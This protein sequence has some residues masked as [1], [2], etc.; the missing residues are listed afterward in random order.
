MKK[1]KNLSNTTWQIFDNPGVM[2][3]GVNVFKVI[4]DSNGDR[5]TEIKFVDEGNKGKL[6]YEDT[7]VAT[8]PDG[9]W[10]DEKFQE[11]AIDGGED[12]ANPMLIS[13]LN[14]YARCETAGAQT[15]D[16][17]T[18]I[19]SVA[20]AIR[21]EGGGTG[22]N[23]FLEVNL[24]YS[25]QYEDVDFWDGSSATALKRIRVEDRSVSTEEILDWLDNNGTVKYV[26]RQSED[27]EEYFG[28][29][30][31]SYLAYRDPFV[32]DLQDGGK[33]YID[34]EN[35]LV[36]F[37]PD[38]VEWRGPDNDSI[39][40]AWTF[41]CPYQ[42]GY[43]AATDMLALLREGVSIV[44]GYTVKCILDGIYYTMSLSP[45]VTADFHTPQ[46]LCLY[47]DVSA[48]AFT[49]VGPIRVFVGYWD[50]E[51]PPHSQ[52]A[53]WVAPNVI[54]G[55]ITPTLTEHQFDF[56][57]MPG[58]TSF[59]T[60]SEIFDFLTDIPLENI[61]LAGPTDN[62]HPDDIRFFHK[63][64][65]TANNIVFNSGENYIS[66]GGGIEETLN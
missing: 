23:A 33:I 7:C 66:L 53:F 62:A 54:L 22:G 60:S 64:A 25:A 10:E 2:G 4:F 5:Y 11:I 50:Q 24:T 8:Y 19:N 40:E 6:Y 47:P 36:T 1:F 3:T 21:E 52:W 20:D 38:V 18:A 30:E 65:Y 26:V 27:D 45:T 49:T 28:V 29:L 48:Y 39:A 57:P 31:G 9:D 35:S 44:P 34:I 42:D 13:W 17:V 59:T 32:A 37:L 61:V 63:Y 14:K 16:I 58:I 41:K 43:I 55:E 12:V 46:F 56:T 15:Q 51:N